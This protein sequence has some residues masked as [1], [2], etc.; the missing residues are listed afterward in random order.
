MNFFADYK[1]AIFWLV[2]VIVFG[3]IEGMT[4]Q[5]ASIWF[6]GGALVALI[7]SLFHVDVWIQAVVF[8]GVSALL[9]ALTRPLVKKRLKATVVP[10]NSDAAIGKVA[11]VTERIDNTGATGF[12]KLD[13]TLWS[14]RSADGTPVEEGEEVTVDRIEGVKLI[15]SRRVEKTPAADAE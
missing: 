13:G 6:A 3:I 10:T 5:L 7:V 11:I 8:V 1:Y 14:A 12:V 2:L 4:P 15:V 9:L